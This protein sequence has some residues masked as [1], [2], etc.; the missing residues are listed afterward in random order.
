MNR[1]RNSKMGVFERAE[2]SRNYHLN[3]IAVP[4]RQWKT[5]GH[6]SFVGSSL[7]YQKGHKF[8]FYVVEWGYLFHKQCFCERKGFEPPGRISPYETLL[9]YIELPA[10]LLEITAPVQIMPP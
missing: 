2:K 9:S 4:T 5:S 1:K 6:S 7:K 3:T 10:C 8:L